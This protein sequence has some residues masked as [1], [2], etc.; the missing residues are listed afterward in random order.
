MSSAWLHADAANEAK[1]SVNHSTILGTMYDHRLLRANRPNQRGP[2]MNLRSK[3]KCYAL[4]LKQRMVVT[5]SS[6]KKE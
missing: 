5:R 6:H 4:S 1:R 3:L 2:L